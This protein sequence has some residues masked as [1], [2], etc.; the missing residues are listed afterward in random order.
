M[1]IGCG[2]GFNLKNKNW[3]GIDVDRN[4]LENAKKIGNARYGS[5][6][7]IPFREN[8]F[9]SVCCLEVLEHVKDKEAAVKQIAKVLKHSGKV[10]V[11]TPNR[12]LIELAVSL[13]WKPKFHKV[14]ELLYKKEVIRLF[15][16]NGFKLRNYFIQFWFPKALSFMVSSSIF[17]GK[18]FPYLGYIMVFEFQKV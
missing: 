13:G 17:F 5:I 2:A 6:L 4:A 3:V 1:D 10:L 15:E 7:N 9:D 14:E 18:V 16:D 12:R 11:S 8:S